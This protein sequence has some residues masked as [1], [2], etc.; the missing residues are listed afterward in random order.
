MRKRKVNFLTMLIFGLLLIT[1]AVDL[2]IKDVDIDLSKA[3]F[4]VGGVAY[5]DVKTIRVYGRRYESFRR[6][7]YFKLN[8]SDQRFAI[9]HTDEGYGN[10]ESN[11][12]IG[13]TVKVYYKTSGIEDDSNVFQ[14]EKG[15]WILE[16]Y[17]EYN[18]RISFGVAAFLFL[19]VFLVVGSI[20]WYKNFNL[21][22]FM[23][24]LVES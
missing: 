22:K 21:V 19:G 24:S 4:V 9:Y 2:I 5:A 13:D 15:N 12:E 6:I 23:N 17:E 14:L 18:R 7:F 3:K 1:R 10:L 16:S 8:N 11:L 20:L